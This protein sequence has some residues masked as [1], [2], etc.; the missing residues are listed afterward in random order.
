M[1]AFLVVVGRYLHSATE[2]VPGDCRPL[3][4]S[5]NGFCYDYF[6]YLPVLKVKSFPLL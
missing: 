6:P 2:F 1:L 4:V 3:S 5:A